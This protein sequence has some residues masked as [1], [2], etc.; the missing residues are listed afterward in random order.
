MALS[1]LIGGLLLF[2]AIGLPVAISFFLLNIIGAWVFLGGDAGLS[3][4]VRNS[5]VSVTNFVM[6]PIPLFLL[7]GEILFRTGLAGHAIDA[8]DRLIAKVPGRLSIVSIFGGSIFASLSGSSMAN[9][10]MLGSTLLPEMKARGYHSTMSMG[11]IMGTGGIAVLIPPS[12]LAVLLG[13]LG[14]ISIGDL[15]V[16]GILPGVMITLMY[17]VYVV[18][19]CTM[20]PALAPAYEVEAMS[21]WQKW[22]PFVKYVLPLLGIFACVIG[23]MLAG[24]ATPTESAALGAAAAILAAACYGRL[25]WGALKTAL[26]S[27]AKISAMIMFI[28]AA[29]LT[30]SQILSFSGATGGFLKLI[31]GFDLSPMLLLLIMLGIAM[32]LGSLMDPISV[33][34]IV[35]PFFMPLVKSMGFDLVWF[36]VLMLVVLEVGFLT[37]PVGML[38]FVMKGVA[39]PGTTMTEII[40]AAM[41]FVVLQMLAVALIILWPDIATILPQLARQ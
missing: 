16:A 7:M 17:V 2:L 34:M 30:F 21:P 36:G 9:T 31:K 10:A 13:S 23:S 35:L 8:V 29:S 38:L 5:T 22:Q 4:L 18:V 20:N 12:G 32:I 37:P 39:P 19:R 40:Q 15:L 11:P 25:T 41:P 24:V 33:M 28:V 1:G 3:Q 26:Y 14:Q 6:V 27:T